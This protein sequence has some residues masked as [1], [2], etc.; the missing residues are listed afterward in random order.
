MRR[1]R[2]VRED[3]RRPGVGSG[4]LV[5]GLVWFDLGCDSFHTGSLVD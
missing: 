4:G 5:F 1:W 3:L 2:W